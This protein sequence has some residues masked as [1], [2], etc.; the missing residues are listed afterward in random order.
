MWRDVQRDVCGGEVVRP[1]DRGQSGWGHGVRRARRVRRA[2]IAS[3]SDGSTYGDSGAAPV[4]E[5]SP[6]RWR[7]RGG[8]PL[9]CGAGAGGWAAPESHRRSAHEP[10]LR[11]ARRRTTRLRRR[12]A[13][14]W[15]R[16]GHRRAAVGPYPSARQGP[17]GRGAVSLR[18]DRGTDPGPPPSHRRSPALRTPVGDRDE[19]GCVDVRRRWCGEQRTVVGVGTLLGPH[20]NTAHRKTRS[21]HPRPANAGAYVPVRRVHQGLDGVLHPTHQVV[22]APSG[23]VGGGSRSQTPGAGAGCRCRRRVRGAPPGPGV[24]L[25]RQVFAG[26]RGARESGAVPS[27]LVETAGDLRFPAPRFPVSGFP[28]HGLP[29]PAIPGDGIPAP[30]IAVAAVGADMA[31]SG[32]SVL[33]G[34]GVPGGASYLR[35]RPFAILRG[36]SPCTAGP[37]PRP[38]PRNTAKR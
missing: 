34:G 22:S 37:L 23:A 11:A 8:A 1:R 6:D 17:A 30:G 26:E 10:R 25:A 36:G 9:R 20:R 4:G 21:E 35:L 32:L 7:W 3:A 38:S 16:T 12:T 14:G 33:Q 19:F 18:P 2:Q 27:L 28:A 13:H 24:G 5:P 31:S 15:C 29:V